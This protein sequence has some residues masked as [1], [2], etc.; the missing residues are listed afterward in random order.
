MY[1]VHYT[2]VGQAVAWAYQG[3]MYEVN[4]E[5]YLGC[6]TAKTS[7]WTY[8]TLIILNYNLVVK[9]SVKKIFVH[10]H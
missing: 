8:S 1:S 3:N 7:L 10:P 2:S 4:D 9:L 6:Q 5:T